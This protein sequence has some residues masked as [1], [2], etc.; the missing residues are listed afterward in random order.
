MNTNWSRPA[1]SRIQIGTISQ[2]SGMKA[3]LREARFTSTEPQ[4]ALT[5]TGTIGSVGTL[6]NAVTLRLGSESDGA[7]YFD[8]Q[9]DEAMLYRYALTPAQ[10]KTDYNQGAVRFGPATGHP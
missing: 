4:T 8:G 6:V 9:L 7:N 1:H 5:D 2:L 10:I 3:L